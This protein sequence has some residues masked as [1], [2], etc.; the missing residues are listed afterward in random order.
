MAREVA[1]KSQVVKR[2]VASQRKE[3]KGQRDVVET[4]SSD[5]ETMEKKRGC[6]TVAPKAANRRKA[7]A[8]E[9][10]KNPFRR[11]ATDRG[12]PSASDRGGRSPR[13][14]R[15]GLAASHW[16]SSSTS[17][18]RATPVARGVVARSRHVPCLSIFSS[19]RDEIWTFSAVSTCGVSPEDAWGA[20]PIIPPRPIIPGMFIVPASP[21]RGPCGCAAKWTAQRNQI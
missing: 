11:D 5:G 12:L 17:D 9:R 3:R 15:G 14:R 6:V 10:F 18:P 13:H 2:K 16:G 21:A 8:P 4:V 1:R 20:P 19:A 7:L